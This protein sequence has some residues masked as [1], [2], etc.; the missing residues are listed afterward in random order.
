MGIKISKPDQRANVAW[1]KGHFLDWKT[2][3][4]HVAQVRENILSLD[5]RTDNLPSISKVLNLC[6][7][8]YHFLVVFTA[9]ML[10]GRITVMPS[11]RS[12]GELARM[13]ELNKGIQ[14]VCDTDIATICQLDIDENST[15]INWNINSIP[16]SMVV[17]ELYTSGSTGIP[18]ANPKTWGQLING[19]QQVYA[20]FGLNKSTP[21]IIATVPPQHMFGFEISIVMP[22]VCGAVIHCDQPFYPLDIQRAISAMP[23]PRVLVTTPIH[24]KACVTLEKDW[25]D[26]DFV[27]SATAP[28]PENVAH[29]AEKIMNTQVKEIYG[30]SEVGAIATRRMIKK[31]SWELFPDYILSIENGN[32]LLQIPTFKN[33]ISL[34]DKVEIEA[35]GYFK[36]VGRTADLIKIGGKRGSILEIIERIKAIKGVEDA[37]VFS[38]NNEND[39]VRLTALVVAPEMNSK[40]IREILVNEIDPVFLP[41]PLC[42]VPALP[43]NTIGKLP[44]ANLLESLDK[45]IKES[46]SC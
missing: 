23:S 9:S 22:L 40:Q 4:G 19:A 45:Y 18:C 5:G 16:V 27:M 38:P 10:E 14:Q 46:K 44:R 43:Y 26:I 20:R 30:C 13:I 42:V 11:N 29:Q 2:F 12:E 7:N 17:A 15:S 39:R 28:M 24:L 34:P 35:G 1:Y 37:V 31:T 6:E 32:T 8:R 33:P 41:R 21:S 36:L 3:E 25:S